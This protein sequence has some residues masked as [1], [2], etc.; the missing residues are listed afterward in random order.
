MPPTSA[1]GGP[2]AIALA[3]TAAYTLT[4]LVARRVGIDARLPDPSNLGRL[5]V[6]FVVGSA[7]SASAVV[8]IR[9]ST[10][11]TWGG[12]LEGTLSWFAADL[13]GMVLIVPALVLAVSLRRRSDRLVPRPPIRSFG[14][15]VEIAAVLATPAIT[16]GLLDRVDVL[17]ACVGRGGARRGASGPAGG[18]GSRPPSWPSS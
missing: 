3:L 13:A 9:G 8:A 1:W 15:A 6:T 5:S 10:G 7:M 18:R 14:G 17:Y 12:G 11:P 4:G 2:S 16:V